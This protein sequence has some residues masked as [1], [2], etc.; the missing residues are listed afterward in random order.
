MRFYFAP[1][2]GIS[3]YVYRNAYHKYFGQVDKYFIP[4]IMPNQFGHLSS[5]EKN[6]ILPEHNEGMYAVP[7]ILTSS[8]ED[9]IGTAQKLKTYG[10]EEV[11]LNLG[12]PS[13]TVVTKGRGSGFLAYPDKLDCFLEEIFR[14]T[15]MKISIKTRIGKESPEEFERLLDIYNQYPLEEL[16][17]HP[18]LQTDM[19]KNTPNWDVF[20]EALGKCKSQVCYNGDIFTVG[21]YE[22]FTQKF[23]EVECVM[24][25][26]GIL[27]NPGLVCTIRK[28]TPLEKETLK[29]FH[30]QVYG[31]YQTVL[32]GAKTIL[33]KMK[34][35]W[36]YMGPVFTNYEKYVKK[37]R[38]SEK[39]SVY[40]DVVERLFVEQ[41]IYIN[42]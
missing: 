7:Q 12:C 42:E 17:I 21:D 41:E 25:G 2:E 19:Y 14:K 29:A 30:D 35:M 16:I 6:D 34:E 5:R 23:P 26:R 39:L 9:F 13:K 40:E 4:F 20:G 11:N 37:I 18:R 28:G 8:A 38:K 10:Y 1:L 15:D 32:S 3:G 27:S 33:F 36:F 22:R 31:E 24:L